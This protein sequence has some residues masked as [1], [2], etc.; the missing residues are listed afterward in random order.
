MHWCHQE[1]C[2]F[3]ALLYRTVDECVPVMGVPGSQAAGS[4][5]K[6]E[7]KMHFPIYVCIHVHT[8]TNVCARR[9]YSV[10]ITVNNYSTP[11]HYFQRVWFNYCIAFTFRGSKFSRI[12]FWHFRWNNFMNMLSRPTRIAV[13]S[14]RCYALRHWVQWFI[15]LWSHAIVCN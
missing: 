12:A 15:A 3:R 7:S 13:R 8:Y 5:Q 2:P 4:L 11:R 6:V 1:S 14:P 10:M 9:Q